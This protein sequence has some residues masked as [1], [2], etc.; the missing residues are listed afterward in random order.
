MVNV[1]PTVWVLG[2]GASKGLGGP[3][4]DDL[5]SRANTELVDRSYSAAV[6]IGRWRSFELGQLF[7][8][9]SQKDG[10]YLLEGQNARERRHYWAHAEEF[11]ETIDLAT[12]SPGGPAAAK[13]SQLYKTVFRSA[14]TTPKDDLTNLGAA[15]RRRMAAECSYFLEGADLSSERWHPYV[16]WARQLNAFDTVLCF[17]YDLVLDLL[18]EAHPRRL[19][20]VEPARAVG[21]IAG[22]KRR[23]LLVG[24]PALALKLHGSLNWVHTPGNRPDQIKKVDTKPGALPSMKTEFRQDLAI[25]AP[26]PSKDEFVQG[27]LGP[28]W[29]EAE[30]VLRE[31]ER[32]VFCGY[33]FPPTDGISAQRLLGAI[34]RAKPQLERVDIVLGPNTGADAAQRM[35]A[36]LEWSTSREKMMDLAYKRTGFDDKDLHG[37]HLRPFYA[38]DYFNLQGSERP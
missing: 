25:A 21:T 16:S 34:R 3:L 28:L 13:I 31:A 20:V 9:G 26:G 15:A 5:F 19:K 27:H 22:R 36:L 8:L 33:S 24:G 38:E 23:K 7:S 1:K 2:A 18:A 32:I 6:N 12:R 37:V 30:R 14:K 17:N 10:D 11:L 35:E 29:R 4:L